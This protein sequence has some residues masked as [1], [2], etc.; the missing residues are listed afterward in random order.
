MR[1]KVWRRGARTKRGGRG[2]R[3][4]EVSPPRRR[5][6]AASWGKGLGARATRR[7]SRLRLSRRRACAQAGRRRCTRA[8]HPRAGWCQ[9]RT[10]GSPAPA[11]ARDCDG[12]AP[13]KARR[14]AG[15]A[16][17]PI[18]GR[19]R[20]QSRQRRVAASWVSRVAEDQPRSFARVSAARAAACRSPVPAGLV[21]AASWSFHGAN[22]ARRF[23]AAHPG[24]GEARGRSAHPASTS[25]DPA[26]RLAGAKLPAPGGARRRS[27]ARSK[28]A[29]DRRRLLPGPRAQ[30]PRLGAGL[31][32]RL[33][34]GL[35]QSLG[36]G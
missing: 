28:G 21:R 1:E 5:T 36:A 11:R 31:R 2:A 8:R 35:S 34:L 18:R 14:R 27:V 3:R 7:S 25:S 16:G 33:G 24:F 15:Q 6:A 29:D 4:G 9:E 20:W 17:R 13:R 30:H 32:R 23:I 26:G 12:T 19:S 22:E 10:T